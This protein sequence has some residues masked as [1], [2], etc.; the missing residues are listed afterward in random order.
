MEPHSLQ[1]LYKFIVNDFC[2]LWDS[3]A[4]NPKATGRGNFIFALQSMILLELAAKASST[5]S[6]LKKKFKEALI[7]QESR[8]YRKLPKKI[9]SGEMGNYLPCEQDDFLALLYDVTRNGIAHQYTQLYVELSDGDFY[10]MYTGAE[11]NN[12]LATIAANPK[13]ENHMTLLPKDR[14]G[15]H[16]CII[17]TPWLF[18]DIKNAT[19]SV[20]LF[21]KCGPIPVQTRQQ[22][23]GGREYPFSLDELVM[24]FGKEM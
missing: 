13:P 4:S 14:H 2:G 16:G 21:N 18:L 1:T 17:H 5:S 6:L 9:N 22:G 10:F 20:D 7:D 11:P 19:E 3:T 12:L 15:G 24:N 23:M 8:F